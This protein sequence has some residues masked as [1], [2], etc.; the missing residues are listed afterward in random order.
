M[1]PDVSLAERFVALV[2]VSLHAEAEVAE[3]LTQGGVVVREQGARHLS[4]DEAELR[5]DLLDLA[6]VDQ[7]ELWSRR[8]QQVAR[9][10]VGVEEAVLQQHLPEGDDED[11]RH[12]RRVDAQAFACPRCP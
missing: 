1:S 7:D 3:G 12:V 2:D 4:E 8:H 6:E 10:R 9:V 5:A 11:L